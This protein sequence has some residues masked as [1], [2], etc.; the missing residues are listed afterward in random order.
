MKAAPG[1]PRMPPRIVQN[2][3]TGRRRGDGYCSTLL[4]QLRRELGL[5]G[6]ESADLFVGA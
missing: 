1:P 2:G 6:L 3:S 5:R 4:I